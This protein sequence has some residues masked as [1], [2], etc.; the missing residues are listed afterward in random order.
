MTGGVLVVAADQAT[1]QW[2]NNAIAERRWGPKVYVARLSGANIRLGSR[3]ALLKAKGK[4]SSNR[5]GQ[6]C[7]TRSVGG[8]ACS[9]FQR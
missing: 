4:K 9:R 2:H 1:L 6:A 3:R 5:Q 8:F 7:I